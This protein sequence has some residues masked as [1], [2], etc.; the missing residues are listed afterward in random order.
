MG[1]FSKVWKGIKK[2]VKKV[3]RGIKKVVKKVG[4]AFGK[5]GVVGQIGLMFL[6]P[7][8]MQGLGTFWKGFGGFANKLATSQGVGSQIFGK[9]LSTIHTAGSMVGKVYTGITNTIDAAF[10]VATGKGTFK[11]LKDA[12]GS[13]FSGP[14]NEAKS[15]LT[16][17]KFTS[18]KEKALLDKQKLISDTVASVKD[19]EI[20]LIED[21]INTKN[22]SFKDKIKTSFNASTEIPDIS[23]QVTA[24]VQEEQMK[25]SL[26]DKILDYGKE[27]LASIPTAFKE[28][29][30]GDEIVGGAT[31]GVK[32]RVA[33]EI[34]NNPEPIYNSTTLNIPSYMGMAQNND[35][36]FNQVDLTIQRDVGN[37]YALTAIKNYDYVQSGLLQDE[38]SWFHNRQHAINV[39]GGD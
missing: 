30:L 31:A 33:S 17:E 2:T 29:N 26:G 15:L 12:A 34:V 5:L 11:D 16:G 32:Q 3:A 4:K 27:Q 28:F 8:A 38:T 18:F 22:P 13:I 9:A 14:T 19:T 20:P 6:M 35:S 25:K 23:K 10:D 39:A 21:V 7:Y 24:K 36:I 37:P 1:I